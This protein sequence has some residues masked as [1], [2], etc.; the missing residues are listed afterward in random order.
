M[1][2]SLRTAKRKTVANHGRFSGEPETNWM[3]E[4]KPDR[5]MTLL[6]PFSFQDPNGKDWTAPS[7]YILDGASIPRALWTFR[8]ASQS[9][10]SKGEI[11]D[12]VV[13]ERRTDQALSRIA[14]IDLKG[15]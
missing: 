6:K 3:T 2:R 8:I 9:V 13:I 12:P 5:R 4:K 11:D 10:L 7:S 14:G 1:S 15:V